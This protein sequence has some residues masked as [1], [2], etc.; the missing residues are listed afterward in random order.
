M[1]SATLLVYDV[2]LLLLLAKGLYASVPNIML[3]VCEW[4]ALKHK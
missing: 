2:T 4:V 3:F 1:T